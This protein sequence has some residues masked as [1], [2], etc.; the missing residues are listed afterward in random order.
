[1]ATVAEARRTLALT[2]LATTAFVSS[3]DA[4]VKP[5]VGGG[6]SDRIA[7]NCA[8]IART[9]GGR[10]DLDV[11]VVGDAGDRDAEARAGV[12][13]LY[14]VLE[15]DLSRSVLMPWNEWGSGP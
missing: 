3:T 9:G 5:E 11:L 2:A 12:E 8:R 13:P 10:L 14:H 4:L 7:Q 15:R 6:A 1:M